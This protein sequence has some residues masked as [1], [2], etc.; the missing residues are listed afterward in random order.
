MIERPAFDPRYRVIRVPG[1]GVFVVAHDAHVLLPGPIFEDVASLID[2]RRT[3]G[4]IADVLDN[5][6]D[7]AVTYYTLILLERGGFIGEAGSYATPDT[8]A[9]RVELD[10][11][12]AL[13]DCESRASD[14]VV[15]DDYFAPDLETANRSAL[16]SGRP[17]LPVKVAGAETWLGPLFVPGET[18]C[19][20]CLAH[21]LRTTRPVDAYLERKRADAVLLASPSSA[22][23]SDLW[24][25]A[26]M[27]AGDSRARERGG[28]YRFDRQRGAL[29]REIIRRRPQCSACGNPRLYSQRVEHWQRSH[30]THPERST[31]PTAV[32]AEITKLTAID[33]ELIH[34]YTSAPAAI[35]DADDASSLENALA[36]RCAGSGTTNDRAMAAIIGETIERY[37]GTAQ[38]DEPS[39]SASFDQLGDRALHPNACMLFS[40]L[41]YA[42]RDAWNARNEPTA[43]VPDPFDVTE[44]L[45]WTPAWSLTAGATRFLPT[46]FLYRGTARVSGAHMCIADSN[47]CAA[48]HSLSDA[49]VRGFLELV[50]RDSIALWW[51]PR[52]PCPGVDLSRLESSYCLDI[53]RSYRS[54]GR[55]L[56]VLDITTD[57]GVPAYA[58]VS[59]KTTSVSRDEIVFGFGAH[60]DAERAIT[61][62]ITEM[63]QLVAALATANESQRHPSP[64]LAAWLDSATVEQ[65]SYLLPT[66]VCPPREAEHGD[67]SDEERAVD[68]CRQI[69]ESRGMELLVLDQTRA[70]V[71]LSSVKVMVPGLRPAAPRFA[72]GRLCFTEDAGLDLI[73]FF[74]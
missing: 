48:G 45:D 2:G 65:H 14:L 3:S 13:L 67:T 21:W 5:S 8:S 44:V 56:W 15:V 12:A 31:S 6:L 63:N 28:L 10:A 46:A 18:A 47:G 34:V 68:R 52:R 19:W 53:S 9:S 64:A 32:T 41:Q 16:S 35:F 36:Y 17:W 70:D 49:I 39:I 20:R 66:G 58:A 7:R 24:R 73:P 27:I 33:N 57:L 42:T 60:F 38:G 50:E 29:K 4:E 22:S 62:A 55:E 11:I 37:S 59:R 74:L 26:E 54:L 30:Q 23:A 61:H 43:M 71:A 72:P 69:V 51:Y 1:D 25:M 40:D